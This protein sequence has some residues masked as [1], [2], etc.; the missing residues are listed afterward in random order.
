MS[1]TLS[2]VIAIVVV[3]DLL[4]RTLTLSAESPKAL[5][6]S[7][8]MT[9]PMHQRLDTLKGQ[10]PRGHT[11]SRLHG[12]PEKPSTTH[13]RR[14]IPA[15]CRGILRT[16]LLRSIPLRPGGGWPNDPPPL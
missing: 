6:I 5:T 4:H 11:R 13:R 14:S 12:T 15:A 7:R 16:S 9:K 8:S 10:R 3:D 2:P 1:S